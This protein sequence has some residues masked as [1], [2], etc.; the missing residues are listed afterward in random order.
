MTIGRLLDRAEHKLAQTGVPEPK[1]NAEFLM[2]HV[3]RKGR[4]ELFLHRE[5]AVEAGQACR[6]WS[7]VRRRAERRPLAYVLESQ[8]FLGMELEVSAAVLVPRPETEELA[9]LSSGLLADMGR[10]D[11]RI[12][13]I[14]TGSGCLALAL[15][16]GFPGARI[17]AMDISHS[18]LRMARR[19]ARRIGCER[20]LSFIEADLRCEWPVK[21]LDLVVSNPP[22]IPS[23]RIPTLEPEV[24]AEPLQALDGGVDGLDAI[25]AIARRSLAALK[26]GG[27][28]AMEIGADQGPEVEKLLRQEGF[29]EPSLSRDAQGLLRFATV[30]KM[31]K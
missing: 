29:Y 11:L 3:L 31:I 4:A 14:G 19:N 23:G 25:A 22:Y 6:F 8:P 26:P 24:R 17:W 30:R 18:A 10:C 9:V 7:L 13:D 12:L 15:A 5:Q 20:R 27:F 21:E 16:S 28:L 1:A 2:A